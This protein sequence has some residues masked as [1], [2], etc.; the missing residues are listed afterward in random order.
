[1]ILNIK[2]A[3]LI[4]KAMF[5]SYEDIEKKYEPLTSKPGVPV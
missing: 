1:M 2:I 5:L 4:F 3:L